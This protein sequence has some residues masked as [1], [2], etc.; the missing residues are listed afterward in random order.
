MGARQAAHHITTRFHHDTAAA[1]QHTVAT[2]SHT[3]TRVMSRATMT[4]DDAGG[5]NSPSAGAA[6]L[7]GAKNLASG[8]LGG[9]AQ[10]LAGHPFDTVK[11]KLQIQK[12]GDVRAVA[13]R[14]CVCVAAR[15]QKVRNRV[16]HTSRAE[17]VHGHA[18]MLPYGGARGGLARPVPGRHC[19]TGG[20]HGAQRQRLLLLR[21][22]QGRSGAP[23]RPR[24]RQAARPAR[25]RRGR[26]RG[27]R[28]QRGG[29]AGGPVQ[30]QAPRPGG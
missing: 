29:D 22:R 8:T 27:H 18:P 26:P 28:H 25:L 20:R 14:V 21:R 11:T 2:A 5:V 16:V 10:V 6:V 30:D 12:A 19:A 17:Q 9:V 13:G 7:S 4:S 23:E 15:S 1:P 24:Q 3:H